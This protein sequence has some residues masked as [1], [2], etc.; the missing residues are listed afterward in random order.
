MDPQFVINKNHIYESKIDMIIKKIFFK[1]FK[2]SF[3]IFS[4]ITTI[5]SWAQSD[6]MELAHP[7]PNGV[8]IDLGLN[9]VNQNYPNNNVT[10][11]RIDRRPN[12]ESEWKLL[13]II[14]L[15]N[16]KQEF[17]Q[18]LNQIIQSQFSST[19]INNLPVDSLWNRIEKYHRLDSLGFWSGSLAMRL[20]VGSLFFDSEAQPN[21]NYVYRVS[22]VTSSYEI[23][24]SV[25]STPVSFPGSYDRSDLDFSSKSTTEKEVDITW[26]SSNDFKP[27]FINIFKSEGSNTNFDQLAVDLFITSQNDSTYYNITDSLITPNTYYRYYAVPLDLYGNVGIKT[28][29]III[30][31][32]DFSQG[33]YPYIINAFAHD[34]LNAIEIT[35]QIQKNEL[36]NY[37]EIYKSESFDSGFIKIADVPSTVSMFMDYDIAPM[38]KYEY[39]VR[40][41]SMLGDFSIQ[42]VR[43]FAMI[44][45][46]LEPI[47]PQNINAESVQNGVKLQWENSEDFI[48]GFWVYRTNGIN[49]SLQLISSLIKEM[50]P[51]TEFYDT[52]GTLSGKFTYSYAIKSITTSHIDSKFSDTISIRPELPT[53]PP[54]PFDLTTFVDGSIAK[55]SWN[56]M[57]EV[58]ETVLGYRIY[59]KIL[60]SESNP[61]FESLVDSMLPS[62][63]NYFVDNKIDKGKTYQY[64]ITSVDLFGGESNPA[65][66]SDVVYKIPNP[67]PPQGVRYFNIENGIIIKW[68]ETLQ[69][70]IKEYRVYRYQRNVSPQLIS[71][72]DINSDLK[73]EDKK[74][75]RGELYY[76]YVTSVNIFNVEGSKSNVIAVRI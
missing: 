36:V 17:N 59:R 11:Y 47:P 40:A 1:C 35:W 6:E 68:D 50:K 22:T 60:S 33:G 5:P 74:I 28:E 72:V 29:D 19:K 16:S 43:T 3:L 13:E 53:M 73:A 52:N 24:K 15:P 61:D 51:A 4:V 57:A 25:E 34:S 21:T 8:Y 69:S 48:D 58:E 14:Q 37:V 41:V 20:A 70:D 9:L 23:I 10:A 71:S 12:N 76:Y 55:I 46:D 2:I 66:S 67:L 56:D 49:D 7:A 44:V 26:C 54:S 38:K 75:Q 30:V 65:F 64:A 45:S 42:S 31:A 62:N 32:N 63:Q 27:T 39:Y 18:K